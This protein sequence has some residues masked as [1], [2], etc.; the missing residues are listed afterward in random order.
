MSIREIAKKAKRPRSESVEVSCIQADPHQRD[1]PVGYAEANLEIP[2]EDPKDLEVHSPAEILATDLP[3]PFAEIV[4]AIADYSETPP[5]LGVCSCLGVLSTALQRRFEVQTD[6]DHLEP[7]SLYLLAAMPPGDRKSGVLRAFRMPLD[8]WEAAERDRL[9]PASRQRS[10]EI[11]AARTRIQ[12]LKK[13]AAQ[14]SDEGSRRDFIREAVELEG[15]I[16]D[17]IELPV[18][19]TSDATPEALAKLLAA[20]GERLGVISDEGGIFQN[21]AGRYCGKGEANLDLALKAYD[22]GRVRVDRAGADPIDLRKPAIAFLQCVQPSVVQDA[23]GNPQFSGRGLIQRFLYFMPESR[24]GFRELLTRPLQQEPM[25]QW[26]AVVQKLLSLPVETNEGHQAARRIELS[27]QAYL[28]WKTFQREVEV[29]MR[30]GGVWHHETGWASKLP[31]AVA[32]V[33]AVLHAGREVHAGLSPDLALIGDQVMMA[34]CNLGRK[35]SSHALVAFGGVIGGHAGRKAVEILSWCRRER[36]QAFTVRDLVRGMNGGR[37]LR[38]DR[39]DL[40]SESLEILV[41]ANWIRPQARDETR[42]KGR[43]SQGYLVHP[44]I[45]CAADNADKNDKT[46]ARVSG[47]GFLSATS[48]MSA[49]VESADEAVPF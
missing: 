21:L 7:L 16:P 24:L 1:V 5:A 45:L 13:Q 11:E 10:A 18:L 34:A 4:Q 33:A 32:R 29:W 37:A 9:L 28:R 3:S 19:T 20:Q 48:A 42:K 43:P 26:G 31:G 35:L 38:G 8:E 25:R 17:R 46:P 40:F 15:G 23:V 44:K 2:W 36:L 47:R 6:P 22:G 39:E 49:R 30:P 14:A 12:S 41:E 27:P